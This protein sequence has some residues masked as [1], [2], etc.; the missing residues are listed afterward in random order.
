MLN[1]RPYTGDEVVAPY[2]TENFPTVRATLDPSGKSVSFR[3]PACKQIH[4]HGIGGGEGGHRLSHCRL[5]PD[6]FGG[7]Y[8]LEIIEPDDSE[9]ES[10]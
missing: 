10:T 8:W 6:P 9:A 2:L 7:A 1:V 3:C 5:R 4:T